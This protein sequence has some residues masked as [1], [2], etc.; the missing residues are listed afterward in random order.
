MGGWWGGGG[1][2]VEL[3]NDSVCVL[4]TGRTCTRVVFLLA[5]YCPTF[6]LVSD[7]LVVT[8]HESGPRRPVVLGGLFVCK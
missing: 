8:A 6:A 1:G 2:A 5:L 4:A 3:T 7:W